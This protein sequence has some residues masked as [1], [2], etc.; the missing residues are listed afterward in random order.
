MSTPRADRAAPGSLT[1]E[2]D[3][4]VEADAVEFEMLV[5]TLRKGQADADGTAASHHGD[6]Q[7]VAPMLAAF[8][9]RHGHPLALSDTGVTAHARTSSN[10]VLF[11]VAFEELTF[12]PTAAS[13][14]LFEAHVLQ[15]RAVELLPARQASIAAQMIHRT[16]SRAL[17]E[18]EREQLT[19]Q[20]QSAER[21][22]PEIGS[23]RH[24]RAIAALV[25]ELGEVRRFVDRG[26][27][28]QAQTKYFIGML[29]GL[30]VLAVPIIG[31]W[32]AR[33]I[34]QHEPATEATTLAA[35]AV[36]AIVSVLMRMT[37]GTLVLDADAQPR[38][39]RLLGGIRPV[40]GAVFGA[41]AYILVA[42]D[43]IPALSPPEDDTVRETFYVGLAF[44]A[45][46]SERFAQDMLVSA[47]GR[48]QGHDTHPDRGPAQATTR[49]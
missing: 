14:L 28:R 40:I 49:T 38:D 44:L 7:H 39:L 35:G 24:E 17:A 48:G 23:D 47:Q 42:G 2:R 21:P 36:G 25:A 41:A 43:L 30:G 31:L 15:L 8:A 19:R 37:H 18:I 26:A 22:S 29:L 4:P 10:A 1:S 34:Y 33:D 32:L 45:G 27:Q 11:T 12:E 3:A 16:V 9:A 6:E 46:F 13:R 20:N 5:R